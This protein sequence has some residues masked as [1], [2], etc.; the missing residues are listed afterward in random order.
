MFST[1]YFDKAVAEYN[2]HNPN[3]DLS[4]LTDIT[5]VIFYFHEYN[6]IGNFHQSISSNFQLIDNIREDY[7][8][9]L[10]HFDIANRV[11][12]EFQEL[13]R[14]VTVKTVKK[15]PNVYCISISPTNNDLPSVLVKFME[16]VKKSK[17][18]K[19]IYGIFELGRQ[20][21]LFHTHFLIEFSKPDGLTNLKNKIKKNYKIFKIDSMGGPTHLLKSIRYFHKEEKINRGTINEIDRDYFIN[22]SEGDSPI[23]YKINTDLFEI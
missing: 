8:K 10:R 5:T 13:L 19:H 21:Q 4:S 12:I 7:H 15:I 14:N 20:S 22:M 18:V 16:S 6:F 23:K 17:E 1:Y 11:E 3:M 2:I 9:C